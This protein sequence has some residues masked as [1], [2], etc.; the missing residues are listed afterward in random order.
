MPDADFHPSGKVVI[1]GK[2]FR[3]CER[4][5]GA[6]TSQTWEKGAACSFATVV[7]P[8]LSPHRK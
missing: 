7:S 1:A 2:V 6:H 5:S 3:A 8:W 4:Y